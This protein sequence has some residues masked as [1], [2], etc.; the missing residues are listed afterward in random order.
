MTWTFAANGGAGQVTK[1]RLYYV[2]LSKQTTVAGAITAGSQTVTPA[3]MAGIAITTVLA[4]VDADGTASEAV[5]VTGVTGTTFTATFLDAHA[6]NWLVNVPDPVYWT[7]CDI[8]IAWSG[9]LWKA[10]PIIPGTINVQP[11]GSTASW[12]IGDADGVW[13]PLLVTSNGAE[14]CLAAIYEAGFAPGN[15]S[16]VPDDVAEL[17]SGRVDRVNMTTDAED[18]IEFVLMQSAGLDAGYLPTRLL[19][20]LLQRS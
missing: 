3:S 17:F 16:S 13:F 2:G 15:K 11:T 4:V 8:D 19:S 5:T 6:A 10:V 20:T 14:N 1:Y 7:D 18:T 12:K 9:N